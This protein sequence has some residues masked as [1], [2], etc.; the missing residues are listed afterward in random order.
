MKLPVPVISNPVAVKAPLFVPKI[1]IANSPGADLKIPVLVSEAK[2][3][4]GF[5]ADPSINETAEPTIVVVFAFKKS[6]PS[7]TTVACVPVGTTTVKPRVVPI[8]TV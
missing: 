1:E 2:N 7:H 4:A 5:E 3:A 8:V 6:V